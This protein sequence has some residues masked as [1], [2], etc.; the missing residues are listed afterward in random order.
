MVPC[1][2]ASLAL[3][4]YMLVLQHVAYVACTGA[5]RGLMSDSTLAADRAALAATSGDC[6][7]AAAAAADA[8]NTSTNSPDDQAAVERAQ[9]TAALCGN[10]GGAI[11]VGVSSNGSSAESGGETRRLNGVGTG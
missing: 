3:F 4:L 1:K 8:S 7:G 2:I 9:Q 10:P 6:A 11:G 5:Q